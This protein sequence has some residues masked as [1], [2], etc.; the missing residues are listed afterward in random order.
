MQDGFGI[1]AGAVS[2]AGLFEGGTQI[3]VVEDFAVISDPEGAILVGHG[4]LASGDIDDAEAAM[5]QRGEGIAVVAGGV[6]AAMADAIRHAGE[7]RVR[8]AGGGAS[9]ESCDAAHMRSQVPYLNSHIRRP[10][11][12]L[13]AGAGCRGWVLTCRLAGN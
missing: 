8:R 13:H 10:G 2:M 1:A 6:G 3:G 4:L 7:H 12:A 9:Y 11:R 5:A